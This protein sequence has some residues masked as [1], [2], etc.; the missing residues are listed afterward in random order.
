MSS[1]G[2]VL[3]ANPTVSQDSRYLCRLCAIEL[4]EEEVAVVRSIHQLVTI[5]A[6][7]EIEEDQ[8]PLEIPV[9]DP[10]WC[11]VDGNISWHFRRVRPGTAPS[12]DRY[13]DVAF[14][15]PYASDRNGQT[16]AI[17]ARDPT[18]GGYIPLNSGQPYGDAIQSLGTFRDLR[19]PWSQRNENLDVSVEG[20]C[21]VVLYAS[22][23]QTDPDTR[24]QPPVAADGTYLRNEDR[25]VMAHETARYWRVGA[26]MEVDVY[27]RTELERQPCTS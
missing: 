19:F 5:G 27:T 16:T 10:T 13:S 22:V 23:R 6:Y 7:W 12:R 4:T 26:R 9:T 24:V 15:P 18:L 20:L 11:F 1:T 8:Y 17:L 2:I 21:Q 3:P 25:F 14:A